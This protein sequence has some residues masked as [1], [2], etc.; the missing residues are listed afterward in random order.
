[1][2]LTE[3]GLT[4]LRASEH[5]Q[6]IREDFEQRTGLSPDWERDLVLGNLTAI[7]ADRLGAIGEAL[8]GVYDAFSES[9]AT[10]VQMRALARL[11]GT[12]AKAATPSQAPVQLSGTPGTPVPSGTLVRGGGLEDRAIWTTSADV[13]LASDGTGEVVVVAQEPGATVALPGAIDALVSP[14][15]GLDAVTNAAAASVGQD[16]ER[17]DRLRVRRRQELQRGAGTSI[18]ALRSQLSSLEFVQSASVVDNPDSSPRV[19]F[20]VALEG[21]SVLPVISPDTLTT[22]QRRQVVEVIARSISGGIRTSGGTEVATVIDLNGIQRTV[23]YSFASDLPANIVATFDLDPNFTAANASPALRQLVHDYIATL[24][25]GEPLTQLKICSFADDIPGV[26]GVDVL[27]N[28][29]D[30]DLVPTA[31]QRI[32]A[33]TWSP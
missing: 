13:L 26:R 4:V 20:G 25:I 19:L 22:D 8:Q 17:D 10:G 23:R 28:G 5:L 29:A 15:P 24:Q 2:S 31:V 1:M 11:T 6:E 33:G 3:Q 27:I 16:H 12:I 21:C 9:A 18:V 14:I 30:A 7:M 32:V